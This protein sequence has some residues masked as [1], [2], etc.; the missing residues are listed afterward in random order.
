MK[1]FAPQDD[2]RDRILLYLL[3]GRNLEN[4]MGDW[5][6]ESEDRRETDDNDA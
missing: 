3:T 6:D 5:V 1:G 4:A 2:Q